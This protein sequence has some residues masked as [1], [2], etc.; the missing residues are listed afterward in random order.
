M[1]D[2][3]DP[4]PKQISHSLNAGRSNKKKKKNPKINLWRTNGS[5]EQ[6]TGPSIKLPTIPTKIKDSF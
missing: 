5:D 2:I 6:K 3:D 4:I 1:L